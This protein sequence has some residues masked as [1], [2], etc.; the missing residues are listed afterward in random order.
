MG[1]TVY[2]QW[3][4]GER[5]HSS[6][7]SEIKFPEFLT[8]SNVPETPFIKQ[9]GQNDLMPPGGAPGPARWVVYHRHA[10]T[11]YIMIALSLFWC[12]QFLL[13]FYT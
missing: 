4:Q 5:A 11:Q 7:N 8:V 6:N 3:V 13:A 2:L 1:V 12:T 9:H 10:I